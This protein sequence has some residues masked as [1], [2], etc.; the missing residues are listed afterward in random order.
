MHTELASIVDKV[1]QLKKRADDTMNEL[2]ALKQKKADTEIKLRRADTLK[3][4]LAGEQ[5]RWKSDAEGLQAELQFV[6]GMC[7]YLV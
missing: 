4:S 7:M 2:N 3:G 5:V 6:A 1:N